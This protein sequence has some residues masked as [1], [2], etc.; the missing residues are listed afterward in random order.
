VL[1][2]F[3][4]LSGSS[5]RTRSWNFTRNRRL[6]ACLALST[7]TVPYSRTSI[8]SLQYSTSPPFF[9][10]P[11]NYR[12]SLFDPGPRSSL[13][14]NTEPIPQSFYCTSASAVRG[15]SVA[16]RRSTI[17]R[18][19]M[20]PTILVLRLDLASRRRSL[21]ESGTQFS[22]RPFSFFTSGLMRFD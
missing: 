1:C 20:Q 22:C 14:S 10:S 9:I 19:I 13:D 7:S 21:G 15:E 5:R 11:N 12:I 2:L 16:T 18:S 8:Y 3:C 6:K 4:L 17:G